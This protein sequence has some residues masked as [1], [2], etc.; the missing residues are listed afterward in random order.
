MRCCWRA[1]VANARAA[2]DGVC[3]A[4]CPAPAAATLD[5][6]GIDKRPA[7]KELDPAYYGF[8][9]QDLDRE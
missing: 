5:P 6:L 2:A 7:V 3:C 8:T 9:E 4:C 1:P